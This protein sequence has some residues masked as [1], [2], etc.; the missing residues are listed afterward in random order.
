MAVNV[1]LQK[2]SGGT[3]EQPLRAGMCIGICRKI[4][5][6]EETTFGPTMYWWWEPRYT[7]GNDPKKTEP[8]AYNA[9]GSPYLLRDMTSTKFGKGKTIDKTAKARVRV[10]A[11]LKRAIDDDEDLNG[12]LDQCIDKAAILY[13]TENEAGYL[14][15]TMVQPY[16]AGTMAPIPPGGDDGSSDELTDDDE[17]PF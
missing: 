10:E 12:I 4:T 15:V 3:F 8:G 5:D 11:L 1:Q 6:G 14:N 2:P 9:D 13:L 17:I 16:K 7:I